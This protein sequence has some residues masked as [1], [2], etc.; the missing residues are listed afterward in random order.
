MQ[1]QHSV[2]SYALT[3]AI[4]DSTVD[5]IWAVDPDKFGFLIYNHG[6]YEYFFNLRGIKI[7]PGMIPED[8]F[9]SDDFINEWKGFYKRALKE[10]SYTAEYNVYAGTI[11]LQLT[12]NLLKAEGKVFGISV[13]GKN[14]TEKVEKEKELNKYREHLKRSC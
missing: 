12:F 13:F 6:L 7:Q 11:I 3:N 10:G 14:I 8:L 2:K 5:M 1:N 4:V 9:P